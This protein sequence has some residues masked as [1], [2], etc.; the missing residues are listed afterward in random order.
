MLLFKSN[1]CLF[2]C[3][4]LW[5]DTTS[6]KEE[7]EEN[8]L[9]EVKLAIHVPMLMLLKTNHKCMKFYH[10]TDRIAWSLLLASSRKTR[11]QP[12]MRKF[13]H[14]KWY[15][16]KGFSTVQYS[17]AE[18]NNHLLPYEK[19]EFRT[20]PNNKSYYSAHS[21][22]IIIFKLTIKYEEAKDK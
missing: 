18:E 9:W 4:R 11:K 3:Q 19:R 5:N 14:A 16:R 21:N 13:L 10:V 20:L 2:S 17:L 7:V 15:R 22:K 12:C 1:T 8:H 6:K